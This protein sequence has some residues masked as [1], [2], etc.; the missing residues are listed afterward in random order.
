MRRVLTAGNFGA[1]CISLIACLASALAAPAIAAPRLLADLEP[2]ALAFGPAM[3]E[4]LL[5]AGDK[6]VYLADD[7]DGS[8]A[9]WGS[10]GTAAGTELLAHLCPPCSYAEPVGSTGE[11]AFYAVSSGYGGSPLWIWR[12][13][14]TVGGT[15]L[16]VSGENTSSLEPPVVPVVAG[17]FV[18]FTACNHRGCGL[19]R[20][21]GTAAMPL[22]DTG[23]IGNFTL[24][25]LVALGEDVYFLATHGNRYGLFRASASSGTVVLVRELAARQAPSQLIAAGGRLF[26]FAAAKGRELWSSD[27]T[28]GGTAAVTALQPRTPM[29][30]DGLLVEV[31]GRAWFAADDGAHGEQLWVSDGTAR[32]TVRATALRGASHGSAGSRFRAEH[33]A[34]AGGRLLFEVAEGGPRLWTTNGDWHGAAPLVG[35]DGGCPLPGG[36]AFTALGSRVVF[37]GADAAGGVDP[38]ISD[39]TA[40]GT[41]RIRDLDQLALR[42]FTASNGRVFFEEFHGEGGRGVLWVT[43][44][45]AAGTVALGAGRIGESYATFPDAQPYPLASAGSRTFWSGLDGDVAALFVAGG[46]GGAAVVSEQLPRGASS[47][48]RPF[49]TVGDHLLLSGCSAGTAHIWS[50]AAAGGLEEIVGAAELGFCGATSSS[51]VGVPGGAVFVARANNLTYSFVP[52]LWRTDGT[53]AGTTRLPLP[54]AANPWDPVPLRGE[55][56]VAM[57]LAGDAA[58][59]FWS[60]DGTASGTR[61]VATL[62][63]GVYLGTPLVPNGDLVY[64]TGF[65]PEVALRLWRTDGTGGGTVPLTAESLGYVL[66]GSLTALGGRTFFLAPADDSGEPA[67]WSSDGTPE[68]THPALGPDLRLL[69]MLWLEAAG[70]RLWFTARRDDDAQPGPLTLWVSDGTP[71]GTRQLPAVL[72]DPVFDGTT[73][74]PRFADL[75]GSVYFQGLDD[76]HG[77]ELWRSDGTVAGTARVV[78]LLSGSEGAEPRFLTAAGGRV[79]FAATDRAHGNELWS[80]DG[81]AAGTRLEGDLSPGASWSSPR[82]LTVAGNRLYFTAHDGPHGREPWVLETPV[83]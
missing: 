56:L 41:R 35:C 39:G 26:F 2:A 71:A 19:W 59:A 57:S 30:A 76:E 8:P 81:T 44:G 73:Q 67:L 20:S 25:R 38:W 15:R 37:A 4:Y 83:P 33:L 46:S 29:P 11:L 64:F 21:D 48:P 80:S 12:S 77:A 17:R 52:E 70:G 65:E 49:G 74:P 10:D 23:G 66:D 5:A 27:G 40:A 51:P 7:V 62:P 13:D 78:D 75:G 55:A 6:I 22:V 3:P 79:Y 36:A 50:V 61:P 53:V 9:L 42:A 63:A 60:S 18:Y 58:A 28:A 47:L 43:D 82:D 34:M 16:I 24:S 32:G 69:G 45:T 54:G 14:G 68:G 31:G 72:A 1:C